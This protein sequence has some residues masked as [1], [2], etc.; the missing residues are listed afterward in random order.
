MKRLTSLLTSLS[1]IFVI[2]LCS[3]CL[4]QRKTDQ[5]P[6]VVEVIETAQVVPASELPATKI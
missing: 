3:G 1:L 2:S 6:T 5:E 4:K